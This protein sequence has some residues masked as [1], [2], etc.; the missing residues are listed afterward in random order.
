M[1]VR[2][3]VLSDLPKCQGVHLPEQLVALAIE[4]ICRYAA[5][6]QIAVLS[7]DFELYGTLFE[8]FVLVSRSVALL[9][10]CIC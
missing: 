7:C 3:F 1:A 10:Q 6:F 8:Q 4:S 5:L 2:L 9:I